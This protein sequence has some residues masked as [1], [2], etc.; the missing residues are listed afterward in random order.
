MT[1]TQTSHW[2]SNPRAA[3]WRTRVAAP[4]LP[5]HKSLEGYAPTPLTELP[6][7][8]ADLG[9]GRVFIKD[10]SNRLG[11]PAFKILGASWAVS[12][13]LCERL[14]LDPDT[15]TLELLR[16]ALHTFDQQLPVL[17]TATDGNHGRAVAR[18]A[19]LLGLTARIY[20]PGGLSSAAV[21]AITA[22]GAELVPTGQVY[23][24]VVEL[25]AAST[26][27]KP[28]DVL[29]Q[30]TAWEGYTDVPQWIVD[31]YMTL[32]AEIDQALEEA[33]LGPADLVACPVGVGSLAHSMVDYYRSE[34]HPTPVLLSAE[35]ETAACI[36]QS[37]SAGEPLSV[38]TSFPTIMTGL[39]CGTPSLLGWP[40]I[41]A[42]M[43]AAV[44][45]SDDECR[46][47]IADLAALG[48][49]AGPC[50]AAPLA[51][52]RAALSEP[53]H[54]AQ[55]GLTAESIIVLVSTE[56]SAANSAQ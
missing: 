28:N 43:S 47:A 22:E 51:G 30:D 7:V 27:D 23:D 33:G 6:S 45:V 36:A 34:D 21:E 38:D 16:H 37:L 3:S 8:A 49:D 40:S 17:V 50:G 32:F 39:N 26:K 56:G 55:L 25:A 14:G 44:S 11:L 12:R 48:Q 9:V 42:G 46:T 13:A 52:I 31:G 15:A 54:R 18:M 41:R 1:T 2:Y 24:R 20:I 19:K 10:E 5:F 35:P 53:Q 29:I 4:T